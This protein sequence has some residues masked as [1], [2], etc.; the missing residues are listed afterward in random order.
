MTSEH[1][2]SLCC[3]FSSTILGFGFFLEKYLG[4]HIVFNRLYL[5][6]SFGIE[7]ASSHLIIILFHK[8]ASGK[9]NKFI[10]FL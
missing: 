1:Y 5:K 7:L 10:W 2:I 3:V 9:R 8:N 6:A 4:N